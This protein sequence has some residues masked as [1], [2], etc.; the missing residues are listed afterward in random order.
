MIEA[1]R[2]DDGRSH[3]DEYLNALL[4]SKKESDQE[5]LANILMRFEAYARRGT[6]EVPR[7][8]NEL[9]ANTLWE[10]KAG[11]DRVPFF[12]LEGSPSAALRVT[13]GFL[14]RQLRTPLKEINW[15]LRI[16]REDLAS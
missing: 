16:R 4:S 3:L 11:R 12:R 15:A 2:S 7:E 9:R 10:F 14:K 1:A 6:L 13:H 8:L 5:R